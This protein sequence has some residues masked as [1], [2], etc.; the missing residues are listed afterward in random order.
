MESRYET[1]LDLSTLIYTLRTHVRLWLVPAIAC[2]VLAGG[3]ALIAP[4]EWKASQ[5][6]IIRA[7]A[8]GAAGEQIGKFSDLS[9]MKT[10]QET[11]LELAKSH[12]VVQDTLR[13][14]GPPAGYRHPEKWPTLKDIED[15]REQVDMRPPDGAEFGKTEVFYVSVLSTDRARA[16]Q[17]AERLS[18]QIQ[19]RLQLLRDE[20]ARGM[21]QELERT[22][23]VADADLASCTAELSAFETE[24][25]AD[26]GELRNLNTPTGGGGEVAQEL[27]AVETERRANEAARREFQ[28]LHELLYDAQLDPTKLLATPTS[29]LRSQPALSRLKDALVDAQ[30]R[31]ANLLGSRAAKHP[32][33]LAAS[34]AE[35]L[36]KEQLHDEIAVAI[37]GVELELELCV[38]REQALVEKAA[39]ARAR[40]SRLAGARAEYA[41]LIAAVENR[42]K[43][44]EE[45]Q[46]HLADARARQVAAQSASVI[47]RID[48]VET[49]VRPVG[50]GRATITAAGGVGGL[51]LGLGLVF[52]SA[53]MP[54]SSS[55]ASLGR[56]RQPESRPSA[57]GDRGDGGHIAEEARGGANSNGF[58]LFRGM[59]LDE[60]I[61]RVEGRL[62]KWNGQ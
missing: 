54:H 10:L 49:G 22:L 51:L 29:L 13:E 39:T 61:R 4:R 21:I 38:D 33:V 25:G 27:Q 1:G 14:V 18:D 40:M 6:M 36:L 8:T 26:L 41:N 50:P 9:E 28:Q 44:V 30:V 15:F 23:A 35:A 3:Y 52:L 31:K 7:E 37:E 46:A 5:A 55:D 16:G 53:P 58:G 62:H 42:G 24:M 57:S 48:G 60:A 47:H 17:L 20:R 19:R 45:A 34:E 12:G 59:T 32:F 2:A 11:I 56:S 43:L